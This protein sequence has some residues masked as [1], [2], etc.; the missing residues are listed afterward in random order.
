MSPKLCKML[1]FN[2]MDFCNMLAVTLCFSVVWER[3]KKV[4]CSLDYIRHNFFYVLCSFSYIKCSL[5]DIGFAPFVGAYC[6]RPLLHRM[7]RIANR[8]H[9]TANR[10][11][12][13]RMPHAPTTAQFLFTNHAKT[14]DFIIFC[15]KLWVWRAIFLFAS[16]NFGK[17]AYI[18]N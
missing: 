15:A 11:S 12:S 18:C 4:W 5:S 14:A 10:S 1:D 8:R 9:D 2:K 13:G 16:V 3:R 17:K 6:I 7:N